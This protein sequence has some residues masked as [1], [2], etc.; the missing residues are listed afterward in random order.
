ML[1]SELEKLESGLMHIEMSLQQVL[2]AGTDTFAER[3]TGNLKSCKE[4][5][6]AFFEDANGFVEQYNMDLK[7]FAIDAH[8]KLVAT[9]GNEPSGVE[10]NEDEVSQDSQAQKLEE[11]LAEKDVLMGKLDSSAE[12]LSKELNEV[13]KTCMG[14]IE[15]EI[16]SKIKEIKDQQHDRNRRVVKEIIDTCKTFLSEIEDEVA[17]LKG[18]AE[19]DG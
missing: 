3:V 18:E 7:T 19:E 12:F 10:D 14:K 8:E 9:F 2:N 17:Q 1:K 11:L 4:F 5:A 15:R 16:K 6:N 13:D